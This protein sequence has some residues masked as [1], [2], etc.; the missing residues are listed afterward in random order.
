[1]ASGYDDNPSGKHDVALDMRIWVAGQISSPGF[2]A[3]VGP[4][5]TYGSIDQRLKSSLAGILLLP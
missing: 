5:T 4:N 1:V 2:V 3:P